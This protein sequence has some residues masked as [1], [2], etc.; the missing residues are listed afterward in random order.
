MVEN[1]IVNWNLEG[2]RQ[3]LK[4]VRNIEDA[5]ISFELAVT[6]HGIFQFILIVSN[7]AVILLCLELYVVTWPDV[8]RSDL[9]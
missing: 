4:Y 7:F 9:S 3:Y 5:S 1:R 6:C 8:T 2:Q